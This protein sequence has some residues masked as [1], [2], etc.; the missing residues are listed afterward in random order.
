MSKIRTELREYTQVLLGREPSPVDA[1]VLTLM[2][3]AGAYHARAKEIEM[4]LLDAEAQGAILR[5]SREY[6][7]RTGVVRS[8][9]EMC[10]KQMDLGSRRM[11]RAVAEAE[12]KA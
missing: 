10:D 9:I 5:G 11:T 8:F 7:F 6:K 2:E 3:L 12:G 4:E 1:G